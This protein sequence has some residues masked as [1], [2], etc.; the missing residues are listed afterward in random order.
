[1]PYTSRSDDNAHAI[2]YYEANKEA[3]KER[4]RQWRRNN[5]IRYAYLGQRH[6]SNQRGVEFNLT[7]EQFRDFWGDDFPL[8]GNY[9]ED[10]Q[11]CRYGDKGA[12]EL[13]NIYKATKIE[14]Q[15]GPRNRKEI[16]P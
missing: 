5:P 8:R 12:Y 15:T 9:S 10:M 4:H 14:N 7:F 1:M 3:A 11:M 2:R 6:T 13:G 16:W